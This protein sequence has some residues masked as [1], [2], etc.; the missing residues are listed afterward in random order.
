MPG[1]QPFFLAFL[2]DFVLAKLATRSISFRH[3]GWRTMN[4]RLPSGP[5]PAPLSHER[6]MPLTARQRKFTL[7]RISAENQHLALGTGPWHV[8]I[9]PVMPDWVT[10]IEILH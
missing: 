5:C 8:N 4:G 7:V 9:Q 2:H 10:L 1:F 6:S 3:V